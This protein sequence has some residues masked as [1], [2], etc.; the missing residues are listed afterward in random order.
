MPVSLEGFIE[1]PNGE[2]DWSEPDLELHQYF[3]DQER[4]NGAHLY[5]RRQAVLSG[6]GRTDQP[7]TG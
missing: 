3:N 5:G 4:E 1:G 2:A 7:A 6:A